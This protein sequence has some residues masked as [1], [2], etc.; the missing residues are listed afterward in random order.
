MLRWRALH[1]YNAVHVARLEAPLDAARLQA[2]IDTQ[3]AALGLTGLVLDAARRRYE[4]RG[5]PVHAELRVLASDGDPRQA[6]C[7]EI[8]RQLNEPVA[9]AGRIDPFRFFAI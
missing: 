4:Y 2:V 9:R 1:P 7:A 8:E 5:G 6:V 3:L